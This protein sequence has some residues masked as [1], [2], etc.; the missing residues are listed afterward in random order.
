M[1]NESVKDAL[2][3]KIKFHEE[4]DRIDKAQLVAGKFVLRDATIVSDW[5]S[6]YGTSSFA[7]LVVQ[8]ENGKS[9]TTLTGGVAIVRQVQK[10]LKRGKLPGRI[11]CTLNLQDSENGRQYYVLDWP[12]G[13]A[14]VIVKDTV[15]A[16]DGAELFPEDKP[17]QKAIV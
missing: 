15:K 7:L 2:G 4:L 10:L 8:L 11:D 3:G 6:Q 16:D 17:D 5:D 14:P 9:Y 13:W 1:R 12:D